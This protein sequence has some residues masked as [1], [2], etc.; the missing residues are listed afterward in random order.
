MADVTSILRRHGI[1][2]TPQR[3]AVAECVLGTTRHPSAD[4]VW[5]CVK[6]RHPT[7]SRATI[8]NTLNAFVRKHLLRTQVLRGD[9]V[10]FDPRVEPHHHFIDERTGRIYDVP[11]EAV[12]VR[13]EDALAGFEVHEY[14][15]VMR[16]RKK[17]R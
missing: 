8:Y 15:V 10:V 11:W 1:R 13:G 4:E 3:I 2:V 12:R 6:R 7:V 17:R 14:Q 9:T 16:G 5:E